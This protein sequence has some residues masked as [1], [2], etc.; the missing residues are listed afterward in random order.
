M[1]KSLKF[2]CTFCSDCIGNKGEDDFE[3]KNAEDQDLYTPAEL[4]KHLANNC[5]SYKERMKEIREAF[6]ETPNE[7]K[8]CN[9][10]KF[11][12]F[13]GHQC[14]SKVLKDEYQQWPE[15]IYCQKHRNIDKNKITKDRIIDYSEKK[16]IISLLF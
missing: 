1:I 2:K 13:E 12:E 3:Q 8:P 14:K 9:S 7:T 11:M 5:A 10:C 6:N 4:R 15:I 16:N